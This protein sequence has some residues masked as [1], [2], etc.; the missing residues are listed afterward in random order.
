M[1]YRFL[2]IGTPFLHGIENGPHGFPCFAEGIFYMG[3][4]LRIN[5][6][7]NDAVLFHGSQAVSQHFLTDVVEIFF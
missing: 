5:G 4:N 1:Q 3:W 6:S 2:I 7:C